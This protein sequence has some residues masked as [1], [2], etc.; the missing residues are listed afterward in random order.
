M[1]IGTPSFTRHE[2]LEQIVVSLADRNISDEVQSNLVAQLSSIRQAPDSAFRP[3]PQLLP[4]A[5][6][7]AVPP[8]PLL[9]SVAPPPPPQRDASQPVGSPQP[10]TALANAV[11]SFS[12]QPP[13][14][15]PSL[16][17]P[18]S[19]TAVA[20]FDIRSRDQPRPDVTLFA[21]MLPPELRVT[22]SRTHRARI[23]K[24]TSIPG[25]K[26]MQ[27][28]ISSEDQAWNIH[29]IQKPGIRR[30]EC[31]VFKVKYY[32]G[33]V[34]K[35]YRVAVGHCLT[36]RANRAP[37]DRGDSCPICFGFHTFVGEAC[38]SPFIDWNAMVCRTTH[39]MCPMCR[40]I[41]H[42]GYA[43]VLNQ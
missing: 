27:P 10:G 15:P 14:P 31:A 19:A 4:P 28:M 8:P 26:D 17:L 38:I 22:P 25:S 11:A 41:H 37:H 21:L 3:P 9:A 24:F 7:S 20:P 35:C 39:P 16:P 18:L 40:G 42:A 5:A 12:C 29:V 23:E 13:P 43:C 34:N 1:A 36:S 2:E 30:D 33:D 6:P 32:N